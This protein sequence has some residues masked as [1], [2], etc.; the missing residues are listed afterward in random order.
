MDDFGCSTGE[1]IKSHVADFEDLEV[2]VTIVVVDVL[3]T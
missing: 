3:I 2:I 1:I